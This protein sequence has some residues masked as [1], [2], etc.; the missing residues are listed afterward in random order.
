MNI[1][2][3][4]VT[5]G[6]FNQGDQRFGNSA[7]KQCACISLFSTIFSQLKETGKW[8]S[9]DLDLILVCGDKIYKDLSINRILGVED[10]SKTINLIK[11]LQQTYCF[12]KVLVVFLISATENLCRF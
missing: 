2:F 6:N 5:Y 9:L 10:L 4:S 3:F 12:R 1:F 7:G 11:K 8:K